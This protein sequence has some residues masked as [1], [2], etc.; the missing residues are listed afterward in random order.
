M[1]DARINRIDASPHR[2]V[3][4]GRERE[5]RQQRDPD[6]RMMRDDAMSEDSAMK[7]AASTT[8]GRRGK[9]ETVTTR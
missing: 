5:R 9:F 7:Q 1:T 4:D 3:I 6:R 8:A 2:S